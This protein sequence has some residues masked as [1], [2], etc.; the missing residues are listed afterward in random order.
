MHCKRFWP[1]CFSIHLVL[2]TVIFVCMCSSVI[3]LYFPCALLDRLLD[4]DDD[5]DDDDDE[6]TVFTANYITA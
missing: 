4:D 3:T 1:F 2:S 5:D 6:F